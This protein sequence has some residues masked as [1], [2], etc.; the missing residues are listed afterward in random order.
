MHWLF[1]VYA[2]CQSLGCSNPSTSNT[3]VV[4]VSFGMVQPDGSISP[5]VTIP[6]QVGAEYGW[7]IEVTSTAQETRIKEVLELPAAGNWGTQPPP[8]PEGIRRISHEISDDMRTQTEEFAVDARSGVTFL[9]RYRI[10]EGD[11][12]GSYTLTLFVDGQ[13]FDVDFAVGD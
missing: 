11:P 5:S 10:A 1:A 13:R 2:L 9:E 12:K 8:P 7:L 3:N 6:Y 4:S